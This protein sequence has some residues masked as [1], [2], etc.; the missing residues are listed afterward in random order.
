MEKGTSGQCGRYAQAG[1]HP[2]E[3]AHNA[4][5]TRTLKKGSL[6]LGSPNFMIPLVAGGGF[7]PPTFGL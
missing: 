1:S 6:N 7:E 5:T 3:R 2:I 4:H